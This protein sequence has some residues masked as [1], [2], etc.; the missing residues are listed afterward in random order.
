M[1][2]KANDWESC[3]RDALRHFPV[4]PAYI[5]FI[6]SSENISFF[7][8]TT[9]AKRYVLRLH[10]PEY[11]TL[12]EL[13]SEQLWTE[14]L[15]ES[16]IDVPVVVKTSTGERYAQTKF[17][18][19]IR[20]VGLLQW[21]NG[22]SLRKQF[23]TSNNPTECI[24]I[25]EQVGQLLAVL[26]EQASRWSPPAG[27]ARH[28]LDADGLMGNHPFWGR[29]WEAED[30]TATQCN[31]LLN[32]RYRIF[33][34]LA[35]L[36]R[37]PSVYSMIHAD[38]HTG[39]LI[40]HQNHLHIIDFDDAGFGWHA[41]DFAVAMSE[42]HEPQLRECLLQALFNGYAKVRRLPSWIK[43][44][45]PL[46]SLIRTLA[47]IGWSDSR[48]ELFENSAYKLHLYKLADDRFEDT[49]EKAQDLVLNLRAS[50]SQA[51]TL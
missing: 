48:P 22:E 5:K 29:F 38:L 32:M 25:Y 42:V 36:P 6:S 50:N 27:F 18:T 47:S 40:A 46:F 1:R 33:E 21:V 44:L 10:R 11:H 45:V 49:L 51:Y 34:L 35:R 31:R 39:N 19:Q 14:A 16:G 15:L 30:L 37:H 28:A 12:N 20:Y 17:G 13:I 24:G 26:H 41:Y 23:V 7:V 43:E 4:Q 2:N 9:D 8:R 3:A